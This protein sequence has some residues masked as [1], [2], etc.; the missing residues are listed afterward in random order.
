[1]TEVSVA[2]DAGSDYTSNATGRA[3]TSE[4]RRAGASARTTGRRRKAAGY[5]RGMYGLAEESFP[6][7]PLPRFPERAEGVFLK[8]TTAALDD[9]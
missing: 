4:P 8:S 9:G 1:M 2:S 6:C 5:L 7:P 3:L